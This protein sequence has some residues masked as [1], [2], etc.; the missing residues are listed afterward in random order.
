MIAAVLRLSTF[1][2]MTDRCLDQS[3]LTVLALALHDATDK[4]TDIRAVREGVQ[5]A[6]EDVDPALVEDLLVSAAAKVTG[7]D[8]NIGALTRQWGSSTLT[9]AAPRLAAALIAVSVGP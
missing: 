6:L 2:H 5:R 4:V 9:E 1:S 3:H 7:V 8:P